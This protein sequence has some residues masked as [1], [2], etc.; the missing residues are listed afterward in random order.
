[1]IYG[2]GYM[3]ILVMKKLSQNFKHPVTLTCFFPGLNKC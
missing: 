3:T 2:Y 1:M